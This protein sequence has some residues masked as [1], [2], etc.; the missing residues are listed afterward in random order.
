MPDHSMQGEPMQGEPM[1]GA[2]IQ[3]DCADS[4][5]ELYGYLDGEL[6]IERRVHIQSHL[7]GCLRCYEAFDFEAELRMV[8]ARR[9]QEEVPEH[10]RARVADA[11]RKL[12]PGQ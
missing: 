11:L 4:L 10:L 9:C 2:E 12:E 7:D 3:G 8:V 1:Q 6:T 5:K